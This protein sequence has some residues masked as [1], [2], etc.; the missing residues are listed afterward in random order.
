LDGIKLPLDPRRCDVA[1]QTGALPR[2][3]DA[4]FVL[5]PGGSGTLA[6]AN[7]SEKLFFLRTMIDSAYHAF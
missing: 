1:G 4:R 7:D 6:V 5:I 2:R 3:M